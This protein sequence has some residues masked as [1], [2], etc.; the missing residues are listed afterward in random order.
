MLTA[1]FTSCAELDMGTEY[2]REALPAI[3]RTGQ[4]SSAPSGA[5]LDEILASW[6]LS[7]REIC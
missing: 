6:N 1:Q 7:E 4:R 3:L 2:T 5:E